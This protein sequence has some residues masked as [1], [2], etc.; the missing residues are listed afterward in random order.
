[1]ADKRQ[2]EKLPITRYCENIPGNL[3]TAAKLSEYL[4]GRGIIV[5]SERITALAEALLIPHYRVDGGVPVFSVSES[6]KW[7]AKNL[8]TRVDGAASLPVS[9][10]ILEVK[11]TPF[12]EVPVSIS[13]LAG[14]LVAMSTF[15]FSGIYFLCSENEVV[16]VGQGVNVAVRIAAHLGAKVFDR[17]YALPVPGVE[18]D[19][20]EQAFIRA[21]RPRLNVT[22]NNDR[23][24]DGA[25]ETLAR[26]MA[27]VCANP[28]STGELK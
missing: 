10:R 2:L 8:S 6:R 18:L 17:A 9:Y 24:V 27:P 12:S 15:S 25:M 21:L 14:R 7:I 13:Q 26:I 4:E 16:Y 28:A 1:M 5:T 22:H 3:L 20:V 19:A 11:G 23:I